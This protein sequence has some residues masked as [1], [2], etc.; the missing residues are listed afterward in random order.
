MPFRTRDLSWV[1]LMVCVLRFKLIAEYRAHDR[2][3]M[4]SSLWGSRRSWR[5]EERPVTT[6][7]SRNAL[8]GVDLP[9]FSGMTTGGAHPGGRGA[10]VCGRRGKGRKVELLQEEKIGQ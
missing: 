2:Q 1:A 5:A 9:G 6:P 4:I 8:T 3:A 10:D 7:L